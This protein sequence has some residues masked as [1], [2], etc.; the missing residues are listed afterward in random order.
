MMVYKTR[1]KSFINQESVQ[2]L[3]DMNEIDNSSLF[4]YFF[5]Q[6]VTDD[7]PFF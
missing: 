2:I 4:I 5:L 3:F 7:L 6:I 1:N